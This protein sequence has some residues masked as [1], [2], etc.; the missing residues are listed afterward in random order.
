[1]QL[2]SVAALAENRVIGRDGEVPWPHI[3]ADVRQYRERVAR[4]PVILGRRT[5]D[6]MRDD[7]PGSRQIVVSRSVDAVDVPTAVVANDV[8]EALSLARELVGDAGARAGDGAA[9]AVAA[10][11]DPKGERGAAESPAEAGGA[12]GG[13]PPVYVLGGGAIY[14]L[15][16]PH[17]DGMALSHVHGAYE[18]DTYYP[19]WDESEWTV[20]AETEYDRFTLREWVRRAD[21]E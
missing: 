13:D 9:T 17:L 3:E 6:S 10:E 12:E 2:V 15:F 11:A 14:E 20:A 8:E 19:E 1:M 4:S 16:Q 18:G 21:E 5:F 7:L